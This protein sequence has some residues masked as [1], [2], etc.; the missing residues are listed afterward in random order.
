LDF[1]FPEAEFVI[2]FVCAV[3]TD[4]RKVLEALENGLKKF[5]YTGKTIQ[6]SDQFARF[7][8]GI[9]LPKSPEFD[10]IDSRM[11]A[12]NRACEEAQRNDFLALVAV[13]SINAVR[14]VVSASGL[15]VPHKRTAHIVLTL[16]RSEEVIAL[17]RIY[18][19]G[20]LLVGMY[21]TEEERMRH[22]V[23]DLDIRKQMAKSLLA[24]DLKESTVHG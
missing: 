1:D 5:K 3:G 10:R 22:L 19:A 11:K 21:A 24:R 16:K 20:F 15:P 4:Y 14:Q 9:P 17:R 12:G 18:G 6:I 8:L 7:N 23:E 13:S 2:G